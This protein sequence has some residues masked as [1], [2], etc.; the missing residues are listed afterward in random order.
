M[1]FAFILFLLSEAGVEELCRGMAHPVNPP[2]SAQRTAPDSK[3]PSAIRSF[4]PAARSR[5]WTPRSW[6]TP[7]TSITSSPR[8]T[9]R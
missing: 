8:V 6:S 7:T 9:A 1:S 2:E 5:M 4:Q 3:I